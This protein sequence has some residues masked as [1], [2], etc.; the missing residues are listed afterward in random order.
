MAVNPA[1][2]RIGTSAQR[3]IAPT[4]EGEPTNGVLVSAGTLHRKNLEL[5]MNLGSP[6]FLR[7]SVG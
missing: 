2:V 7:D 5:T 6:V 3:H 4:G 1:P